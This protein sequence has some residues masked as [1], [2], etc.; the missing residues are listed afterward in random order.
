MSCK[1]TKNPKKSRMPSQRRRFIEAAREAECGEGEVV[2]DRA[3]KHIA[4]APPK[5][6]KKPLK[7][8]NG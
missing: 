6:K 2:F 7:K 1:V 5:P 8:A 4:K 3:I